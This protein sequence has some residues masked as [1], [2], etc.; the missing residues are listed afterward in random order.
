MESRRVANSLALVGKI[1]GFLAIVLLAAL[2]LALFGPTLPADNPLRSIGVGLRDVG[3]W[4]S[5]GFGGGYGEVIQ[6]N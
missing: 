1:L 2:A 6:T 4:I 3:T 5:R